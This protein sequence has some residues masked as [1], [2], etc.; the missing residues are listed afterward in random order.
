MQKLSWE[1]K[2]LE[3]QL[4]QNQLK[5]KV[6]ELRFEKLSIAT[7]NGSFDLLHAGHLNMLYTAACLADKLI[8]LLNT[9]E[10]I[11]KYKSKNR[12][13]LQL[14]YRMQMMSAIEFVDYVSYFEE[15]DPC[16]ILNLI[17]PDIHVNGAEYGTNCIEAETVI[18]NGGKVH[19]IELVEGLSTTKIIEKI[20]KI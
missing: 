9:D 19:I 6:K 4:D 1:K 5:Q 10:S 11:K 12:P 18:A 17:K 15:T 8:V 2:S 20:K 3:K 16:R 7:I 14:K 13:I